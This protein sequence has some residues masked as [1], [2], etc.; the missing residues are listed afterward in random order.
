MA[1]ARVGSRDYQPRCSSTA[2]PPTPAPLPR[3]CSASTSGSS[4]RSRSSSSRAQLMSGSP[5]A[6]ALAPARGRPFLPP[7]ACHTRW[8]RGTPTP[9]TDADSPCPD[10]PQLG[11]IIPALE[12]GTD[13]QYSGKLKLRIFNQDF[14]ECLESVKI[15]MGHQNVDCKL[16]P[17]LLLDEPLGHVQLY[18][19]D[20]AVVLQ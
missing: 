2:T 3:C 17:I 9:D 18:S 16:Q 19:C 1:S 14:P 20:T 5:R 6:L 10:F 8:H 13:S 7:R 15:T 11:K 12:Y 4:S